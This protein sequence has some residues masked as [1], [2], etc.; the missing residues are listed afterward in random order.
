MLC[1]YCNKQRGEY[2]EYIDYNE[3]DKYYV[4]CSTCFKEYIY[5]QII[6]PYEIHNKQQDFDSTEWYQ[7]TEFDE[8]L[9]YLNGRDIDPKKIKRR[10]IVEQTPIVAVTN[11]SIVYKA[12]PVQMNNTSVYII[13]IIVMFIWYFT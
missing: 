2:T 10:P 1:S 8:L 13:L 9:E 5:P 6:L 12:E 11:E 3:H 7:D 4:F